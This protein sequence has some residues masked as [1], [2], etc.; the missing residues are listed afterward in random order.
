MTFREIYVEG[1]TRLRVGAVPSESP[2]LDARV[3]LGHCA[4]LSPAGLLARWPETVPSEVSEAYAEALGRRSQGEPVAWI[5]GVKEFAGRDFF[6]GPG[7]LVP[8]ADTETLVEAAQELWSLLPDCPRVVEPCT[9]SGCIAVTLA[10]QAPGPAEVW[11]ADVSSEA[12]RFAR[13]N[14]ERLLDFPRAVI[15]V[16]S[17]LL[18]S[19]PGP[20]DLI[21]SNPPYLTPAETAERVGPLGWKE[22]ALALDGGDADGLMLIRILCDQ[23]ASS[24]AP[25]G[26]I[27]VEAADAQMD[28]IAEI[29]FH[30]HWQDVRFWTDLSGQRRVA[31][32]RKA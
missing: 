25:K 31:G 23:A 7:V 14:A 1:T 5:V 4:Q 9:G 27:L 11:A 21:V 30:H 12:L 10:A 18:G 26:W 13:T 8:R 24:L 22:P 32:A 6:V 16:S 20:W 2:E 19:L 3:L 29:F 28:A 17:D 15:V